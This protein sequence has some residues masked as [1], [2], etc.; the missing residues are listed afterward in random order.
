[1]SK[2]VIWDFFKKLESDASKAQC[3][4]CS[5]LLSLGS[6]K[7]AKQTISGLKGHL[8]SCHRIHVELDLSVSVSA[9]AESL[10]ILSV[11]ASVSAESKV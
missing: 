9:S 2:N 11:S 6:D 7:P 8:S 10:S 5:K 3:I 1:M 4:E